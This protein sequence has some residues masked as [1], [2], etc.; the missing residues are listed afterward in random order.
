MSRK[1]IAAGFRQDMELLFSKFIDNERQNESEPKSE[2]LIRLR[3]SRFAQIWTQLNFSFIFK[4]RI[5][6]NELREFIDEIYLEVLPNCSR[7]KPFERRVASLY[8][9]YS[10]FVKQ[11]Q[12]KTIQQRIRINYYYLS[13]IRELVEKSKQ[14]DQLEVCYIWYKLLSLKA[15]D[16][17]HV[18]RLMG[19]YYIR[20]SRVTNETETYTDFI[21][22]QFK[23]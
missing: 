19:P 10:L 7:D 8:L 22:N 1:Y 17:V 18:S 4:A 12:N 23:V 20:N 14:L 5:N 3:F 2:P 11:P 13:E 16:F 15:I 6:D 9:L 21:I